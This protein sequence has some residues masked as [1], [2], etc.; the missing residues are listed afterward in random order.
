MGDRGEL[1]WGTGAGGGSGGFG[2]EGEH[3]SR[4][5]SDRAERAV[6]SAPRREN[7]SSAQEHRSLSEPDDGVENPDVQQCD[8]RLWKL[9]LREGQ[10]EL[11]NEQFENDRDF[12]AHGGPIFGELL[13]AFS[14]L[15]FDRG[16]S[17]RSGSARPDNGQATSVGAGKAP[18]GDMAIR[19]WEVLS[20]RLYGG[21]VT[22][23][24][25]GKAPTGD[26]AIKYCGVLG[27]ICDTGSEESQV[28]EGDPVPWG[29]S[30]GQG[31]P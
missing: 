6:G 9:D 2:M 29:W 5:R 1:G 16:K 13:G 28:V 30:D 10:A 15:V 19:H 24:G 18:T 21:Q 11:Q 31:H 26:A 8:Y 17:C 3:V 23:V 12:D 20:Q 22:M 27:R 4:D 14:S 7:V 25:A